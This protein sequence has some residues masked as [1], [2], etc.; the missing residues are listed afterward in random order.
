[1]GD[2]DEFFD[3]EGNASQVRIMKRL[4]ELEHVIKQRL[5]RLDSR[6]NGDWLADLERKIAQAV[7]VIDSITAQYAEGSA[8]DTLIESMT[9]R[10]NDLGVE[11]EDWKTR[12]RQVKSL[13]QLKAFKRDIIGPESKQL[14]C[15]TSKFKQI[16][17]D[18]SLLSSEPFV[19]RESPH[20]DF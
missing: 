5:N 12:L 20:F 7:S 8:N 17:F 11:L 10:V 4:D 2:P 6:Q 18:V 15:Y 1:M 16:I 19:K 3:E 14:T 13:T 9:K